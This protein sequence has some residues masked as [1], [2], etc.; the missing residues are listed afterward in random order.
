MYIHKLNREENREKILEFLRQNEFATL[1]TYDGEKPVASHLLMEIVEDEENLF[2]NGHMSRANSLWKTFEKNIEV[3]VIFQG[4]HTYI[5][6]TWYDHINVPTWDYQSVHVYGRPR[7]ITEHGEA[8]GLLKR[9]IDR[10]EANRD[11]RL[12]GLPKDFVEQEIKGIVAFQIEVT[13]MEANY[14]LSQ[15]RDDENYR[16][17][18]AHLEERTDDLSQGVAQ[19]MRK[20]RPSSS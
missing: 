11:Y 18:V 9:L 4:P 14:K 16:S 7:L 10:H 17:I 2:V 19:A 15:N 1:V 12:E 8:Y 6:P 20:N 5:S 13:R 3:L